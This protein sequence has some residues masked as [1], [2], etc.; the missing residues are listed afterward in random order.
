MVGVFYPT[1]I[2]GKGIG[3]ASGMGRVGMIIGPM[4]TGYLLSGA[5]SVGTTLWIAAVPYV[6]TAGICTALGIIYWR[7]F[8]G[9]EAGAA[10]GAAAE[11]EPVAAL[12]PSGAR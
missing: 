3:Y 8:A 6:I 9:G 4:A 11:A 1:N 2:R 7:H 5:F 10:A 12:E